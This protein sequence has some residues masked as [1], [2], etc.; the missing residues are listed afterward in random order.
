MIQGKEPGHERVGNVVAGKYHLTRLLGSGG[1][2]AVYEATHQFTQR[3]VAVKLM[4]PQFARSGVAAKRFVRES[5]APSTIG[6]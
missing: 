6:W 4:H 1:M 3:R 5:R 2:G